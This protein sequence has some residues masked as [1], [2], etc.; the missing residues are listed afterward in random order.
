MLSQSYNIII[1]S[2][3]SAPGHEREVVDGL[4]Y[5]VKIYLFQIISTVQFPGT[6]LIN[7][8]MQ[9]HFLI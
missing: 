3:I 4:N 8:Q 7:T 9:I 5:T 2:V 1:D 6:N